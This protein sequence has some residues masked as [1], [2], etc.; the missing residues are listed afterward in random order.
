MS[1]QLGI[2]PRPAGPGLRPVFSGKYQSLWAFLLLGWLISYAD[3]TVT[4]PVIS[5]MIANKAGFIG[6]ASNPATLG[7]LVGS[8]F[9]TGYM[10]TQ[11][12]GGRLGDRYGRHRVRKVS[13]EVVLRESAAPAS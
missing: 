13:G 8:M 12:A 3:R 1:E 9:F 6:D 7:G 4:G 5:W 10:L 2:R 11:Y